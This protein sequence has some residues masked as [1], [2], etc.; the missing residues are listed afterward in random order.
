ML[1][2]INLNR[3][4]TMQNNVSD[5]QNNVVV[6][7]GIQPY[8]RVAEG[9]PVGQVGIEDLR[10]VQQADDAPR[11]VLHLRRSETKLTHSKEKA[12]NQFFT[13]YS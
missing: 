1:P 7:S 12:P 4:L 3:V 13:S 9:G 2:V 8:Q 6:K 11:G 5:L 10:E